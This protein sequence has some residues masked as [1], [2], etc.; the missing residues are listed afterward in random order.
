MTAQ[1]RT[2]IFHRLKRARRSAACMQPF[3]VVPI[4]HET[5]IDLIDVAQAVVRQQDV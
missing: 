2:A 4:R 5:M 3:S 1:E